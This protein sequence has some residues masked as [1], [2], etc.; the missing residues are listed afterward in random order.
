MARTTAPASKPGQTQDPQELISGR[1]ALVAIDKWN[2]GEQATADAGV[3]E[4]SG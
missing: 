3:E 2:E 1:P 4:R